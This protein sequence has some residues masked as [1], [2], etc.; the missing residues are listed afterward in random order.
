MGTNVKKIGFQESIVDFLKGI[1]LH[2]F[3]FKMNWLNKFVLLS[4]DSEWPSEAFHL[5]KEPPFLSKAENFFC[6]SQES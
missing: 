5:I 1:L 3:T 6:I 2:S 4:S